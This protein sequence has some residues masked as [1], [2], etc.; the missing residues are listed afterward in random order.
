MSASLSVER[1]FYHEQQRLTVILTASHPYVGL[2]LGLP[3]VKALESKLG[4]NSE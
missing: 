3:Q 1:G 2:P 4:S